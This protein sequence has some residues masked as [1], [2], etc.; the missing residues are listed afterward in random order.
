MSVSQTG[1]HC[2]PHQELQWQAG[3]G[4]GVEVQHHHQQH[5]PDTA[6]VMADPNV[7]VTD[8]SVLLAQ[9]RPALISHF[10]DKHVLSPVID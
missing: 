6:K 5:H 2:L 9:A 8:T 3:G 7:T 10:F 1:N 4:F